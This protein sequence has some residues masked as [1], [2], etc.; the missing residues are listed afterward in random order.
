MSATRRP[1]L[2]CETEYDRYIFQKATAIGARSTAVIFPL[3]ADR[4]QS[5]NSEDRRITFRESP[6]K[7]SSNTTER[8]LKVAASQLIAIMPMPWSLPHSPTMRR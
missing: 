2:K 1:P 8:L 4:H 7:Y 3:E 5:V 6:V